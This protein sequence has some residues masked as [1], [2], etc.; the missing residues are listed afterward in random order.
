MSKLTIKRSV[1]KDLRSL[2]KDIQRHAALS[3]LELAA[4]P[5]SQGVEKL[6]GYE[7]LYRIRVG[8][9]RIVY[10]VTGEDVIIVAVSH[11]KDIK[12]IHQDRSAVLCISR[13]KRS[14]SKSTSVASGMANNSTML[15]SFSVIF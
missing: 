10:E 6:K 14:G 5:S 11:R 4:L 12:Q 1:L 7:R 9:Y 2:P 13:F 15:A 8:D 3:I